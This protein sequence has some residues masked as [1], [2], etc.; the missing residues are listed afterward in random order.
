VRLYI[1]RAAYQ[2]A[3]EAGEQLLRLAQHV[4]D[5]VHF[6]KAHEL[7]G[8]TLCFRGEWVLALPHLEH[9]LALY[10]PQQDRTLS[11][12]HGDGL[13][14]ICLSRSALALWTQYSSTWQGEASHVVCL[15]L[16]ALALWTV[17]YPDQ[18]LHSMAEALRLAQEG[19]HPMSLLW[20]LYWAA[21]LHQLR[22]ERHTAQGHAAAL[23]ML[24][25]EQGLAGFAGYG[26]IIQGWALATQGQSEAGLAQLR[27]GVTAVQGRGTKNGMPYFLALLAEAYG[28]AGQIEAGL[29]TLAEAL[30]A[31]HDTG[32]GC[33]APELHRLRGKLLL[34]QASTRPQGQG[35]TGHAGRGGGM[36]S[37]RSRRGPPPAGQVVGV[38]SHHES[39]P[40]VATA[41]PTRRGP[42]APGRDLRLVH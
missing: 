9:S 23:L 33:H 34:L 19:A 17:G 30:Q 27:Q 3:S 14:G 38:T 13:E 26:S 24:V 5:S 11:F 2:L 29:A 6:F 37:A 22:Q 20:A 28:A 12:R 41:R 16:K 40:A 8:M 31:V 35:L 10:D 36:F 1:T 7:L 25:N 21:V 42:P 15:S 39:G 4:H 18:A 32:E